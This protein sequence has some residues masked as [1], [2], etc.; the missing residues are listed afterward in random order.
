MLFMMDM[1][2]LSAFTVIACASFLD[3]SIHFL[4]SITNPSTVENSGQLNRPVSSSPVE[5]VIS[6]ALEFD[7][8]GA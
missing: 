4:V 3:V 2:A 6:L 7:S 5:G 1:D 8:E